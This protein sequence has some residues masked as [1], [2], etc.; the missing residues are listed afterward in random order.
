MLLSHATLHIAAHKVRPG[1][2]P[3]EIQLLVA[4]GAQLLLYPWIFGARD[5]PTEVGGLVLGGV[6]LMLALR[7]RTYSGE[8]VDGPDFRLQSWPR[9]RR[10]P[11]F[12]VGLLLLLLVLI[13]ALNP[14]WVWERNEK[15]WWLRRLSDVAWLPAGIDAPVERMNPWRQLIVYGTVWLD[16]CAVWI[17]VTRRRSLQILLSALVV[18]GLAIAT[19]GF[20]QQMTGETRVL[21]LREFPQASPFGSFVYRNFGGAYLSLM[22]AAA[23]ALA[24]WHHYEGRRKLAKSTPAMLW[25]LAALLLFLAVLFSLSRGAAVSAVFLVISAIIAFLLIRAAAPVPS[26]TPKLVTFMVLALIVGTA[27]W[28]IRRVDF[29]EIQ[30]RM[31]TLSQYETDDSYVSRKLAREAALDM[32]KGHWLRGVGAGGFRHLYPGY[33]KNKPQ[34]YQGGRLF[35]AHA[36]IDWLEIPIELGLAGVLLIATGCGW[37]VCVWI[38]GRGWRH[39]VAVMLFLG[40]GQT[41]GHALVDFPF[42]NSAILTTWWV[43]LVV[44]LRWLELESGKPHG[45]MQPVTPLRVP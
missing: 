3:L 8:L 34:I 19:V 27:G 21:W 16:I 28:A 31:A 25:L 43:L 20:V 23:L 11:L 35:W 6:A 40:C 37:M 26:T 29:T 41:L 1:L 15:S 33:V 44:A 14:W 45:S 13:Q 38:R 36:H 30:R 17:G 24:M 18:S 39:P 32:L 10:F 22:M 7:P 42:Q 2:H 12:W 9:L 5:F 4:L